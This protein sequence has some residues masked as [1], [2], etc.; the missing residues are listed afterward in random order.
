MSSV[1]GETFGNVTCD[2]IRMVSQDKVA[3]YWPY[4]KRT[5]W[6]EG[7]RREEEKKEEKNA[8]EDRG[9]CKERRR[10]Q[11]ETREEE[12]M[13]VELCRPTSPQ[14]INEVAPQREGR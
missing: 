14:Q 4:K 7:G 1:S 11:E 2:G 12:Q 5:R 9:G 3:V 8:G 10:Q 6:G 13:Q